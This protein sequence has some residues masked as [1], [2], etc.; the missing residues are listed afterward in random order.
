MSDEAHTEPADFETVVE[1][2]LDSLP[3]EL[4]EA[5]SNVQILVE[6]EHP[7]DRH[8][9]GYYTGV[10]LTERGAHY[11]GVLPDKISIYRRPL[12]EDFGHDS[13]LLEEE[14]RITVIHELA[15]HFGIDDERLDQLGWS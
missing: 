11:A 8:I 3:T 13:A 12:Q 2:A 4:S 10:P 14:I 15:H 9:Y 6:D 7:V 1:R 5:I